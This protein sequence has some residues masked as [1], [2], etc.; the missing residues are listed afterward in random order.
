MAD[1]LLCSRFA[2][3]DQSYCLKG[4]R[5]PGFVGSMTLENK[6]AGFHRELADALLVFAGY[7]GVG[8]KTALG[9]GGVIHRMLP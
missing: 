2:L 8:I 5:I 4:K 6:L 9:M 7:A 3:H 1:G